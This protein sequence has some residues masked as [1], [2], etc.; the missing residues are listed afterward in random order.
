MSQQVPDKI[1]G[2]SRILRAGKF[3]WH[4]FVHAMKHETAFQ[5]EIIGNL[6]IQPITWLCPFTFTSQFLLSILALLIP[7]VELLNSSVEA[8]VDLSTSEYHP[9]AKVAKD[10]GSLAVTWSILL[11]AFGWLAVSLNYFYT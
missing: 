7:L 10:L 6:I 2:L 3:S 1:G 5:Q 4:G 9:L 8:A 11:W